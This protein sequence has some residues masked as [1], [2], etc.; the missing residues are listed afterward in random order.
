[1]LSSVR[2]TLHDFDTVTLPVVAHSTL[3]SANVPGKLSD[4]NSVDR[5]C[6][7]PE[8]DTIG[9]E[10]RE[11]MKMKAVS[12]PGRDFAVEEYVANVHACKQDSRT[13]SIEAAGFYNY[14]EFPS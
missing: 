13:K 10:L 7:A 11:R 2:L 12:F 1:M 3:G 4:D 5:T 6:T 9:S 8:H 14:L